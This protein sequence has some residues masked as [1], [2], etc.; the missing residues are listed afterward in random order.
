M[1]ITNE[2]KAKVFAAYLGAR[3]KTPDHVGVVQHIDYFN[4]QIG[5]K[6]DCLVFT[7]NSIDGYDKQRNY[8][9]YNIVK[10]G[11]SFLGSNDIEFEM[12]GGCQL[13]LKSLSEIS[14]E[15]GEELYKIQFCK[16][17]SPKLLAQYLD[18]KIFAYLFGDGDLKLKS[19][20][21]LQSKGYD[22][23]QYLLGGKTLKEAGLAIYEEDLK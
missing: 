4:Y 1:E 17:P 15:D 5:V 23:P 9:K 12:P 3:V 2:I 21:F 11:Y 6:Y 8:G 22:L 18:S 14:A 20:Q 13:I 7:K 10:Q 16:K 19:Y